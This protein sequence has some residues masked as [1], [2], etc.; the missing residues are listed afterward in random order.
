MPALRLSWYLTPEVRL[1]LIA[2]IIG[3]TPIV[4]AIAAAWTERAMNSWRGWAT[5]SPGAAGAGRG[6][7]GRAAAGGRPHLQPV[8]LLPVLMRRALHWLLVASFI[9]IIAAPPLANLVGADGADPE[10]EN[11]TLA[12]FPTVTATWASVTAFLPG[13][14][15]WFA[16]HFAFRS[17]LVRW[18]GISRYFWLGVSSSPSVAVGPQ[19][20]AVLCRRWRAGGLH[21]RASVDRD[22][23]PELADRHRPCEDVVP[24]PGASRTRSPS[25]RTRA[26][27]IRNSFRKPR[28]A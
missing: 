27:F 18:Y 10:A 19:R 8:H 6:V 14:D 24:R 21:E 9:G 23:N 13:I 22:R 1:A 5:E 26:R 16:D 7:S 25:F 20:L 2:G 4:P 11:R 12:A 3:S 17:D 15:A 28:V